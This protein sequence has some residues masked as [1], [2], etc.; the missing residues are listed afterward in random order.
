MNVRVITLGFL[1]SLMMTSCIVYH[2]QTTDVPLI[3]KKNDLRVDAGVSIVPSLHATISYG[4]TDKIA[5]QGFGSIGTGDRYYFQAATGLY[6]DK[7]NS[8]VLELYGG[9]GYGY[10][11]PYKY[12]RRIFGA[13]SANCLGIPNCTD[14]SF[15]SAKSKQ[16]GLW[17][18]IASDGSATP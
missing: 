14:D 15:D 10:G 2:T 3:S 7:G 9:F 12:P 18:P 8:R 1:L 13:N 5:I 16:I 4:L 6:K 11:N 17:W